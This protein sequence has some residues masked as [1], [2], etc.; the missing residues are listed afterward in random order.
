M[1]LVPWLGQNSVTKNKVFFNWQKSR[2]L[3]IAINLNFNNIL[4]RE[5]QFVCHRAQVTI[6]HAI[7]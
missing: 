3:K 5:E 1:F 2:L 6:S 4:A 7:I